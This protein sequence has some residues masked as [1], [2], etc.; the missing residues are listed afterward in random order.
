MLANNTIADNEASVSWSGI[1]ATFVDS[2]NQLVNNIVQVSNGPALFCDNSAS[3]G[4]VHL[5]ATGDPALNDV[6]LHGFGFPPA[7]TPTVLVVRST[8]P[9]ATPTV[10]GDGLLCLVTPIVR[11][12]ASTASGGQSLHGLNHGAGPG[13]FHYQ[14]WYRNSADNFCTPARFNL[15]SG[16]TIVFP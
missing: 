16:Y 5:T 13:T 6:V 15:S 1:Y 14:L 10:F 7:S 9:A 12:A 3:T 11:M 2:R 4:G 8:T